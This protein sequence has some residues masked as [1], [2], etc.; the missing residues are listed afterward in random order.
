VSSHAALHVGLSFS[1][2]AAGA[3]SLS[4]PCET[5]VLDLQEPVKDINAAAAKK[6]TRKYKWARFVSFLACIGLCKSMGHLLLVDLLPPFYHQKRVLPNFPAFNHA[7]RQVRDAG[8]WWT[9]F[10]LSVPDWLPELLQ[11]SRC[12]SIAL[13]LFPGLFPQRSRPDFPAA[14]S[15]VVMMSQS[16]KDW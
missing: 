14:A 6:N 2:Q 16:S 11:S 4:L 7:G 10:E 1:F 15:R 8:H 5:A 9:T 13:Y 3:F 12:L